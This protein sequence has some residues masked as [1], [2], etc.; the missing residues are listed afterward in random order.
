MGI[1]RA[2]RAIGGRTDADQILTILTLGIVEVLNREAAAC[3]ADLLIM[4]AYG[5]SRFREGRNG[6][7]KMHLVTPP[8]IERNRSYDTSNGSM[9]L[10]KSLQ[11]PKAA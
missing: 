1:E 3:S 9:H 4:G 11:F 6:F 2:P 8:Q 10:C 5:Q 7:D